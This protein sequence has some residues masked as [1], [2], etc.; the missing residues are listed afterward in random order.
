M[1][2]GSQVPEQSPVQAHEQRFESKSF[3]GT[4]ITDGGNGQPVENVTDSRVENWDVAAV[5]SDTRDPFFVRHADGEEVLD[6]DWFS[7]HEHVYPDNHPFDTEEY[8]P[9]QSDGDWEQL[10]S[11]ADVSE[12]VDEQTREIQSSTGVGVDPSEFGDGSSSS[13]LSETADSEPSTETTSRVGASGLDTDTLRETQLIDENGNIL[14]EGSDVLQSDA[15]A[16]AIATVA[17]NYDSD[18]IAS[19]GSKIQEL[20]QNSTGPV[21]IHDSDVASKFTQTEKE[22]I[23]NWQFTGVE[24]VDQ[25]TD[26]EGRFMGATV[27]EH[28]SETVDD[29]A[30]DFDETGELVVATH[31][32]EYAQQVTESVESIATGRSDVDADELVNKIHDQQV[33]SH[34]E[35]ISRNNQSVHEQVS[36][37]LSDISRT[38]KQSMQKSITETSDAAADLTTSEMEVVVE[39]TTDAMP[40]TNKAAVTGEVASV[41]GYDV[42][43]TLDYGS[44]TSSTSNARQL[45][46][47]IPGENVALVGSSEATKNS[48]TDTLLSINTDADG[49]IYK[50]QNGEKRAQTDVS[51]EELDVVRFDVTETNNGDVTATVTDSGSVTDVSKAHTHKYKADLSSKTSDV[52]DSDEV[53]VKG[54]DEEVDAFNDNSKAETNVS[55]SSPQETNDPPTQESVPTQQELV[56]A[57]ES[58]FRG[59]EGVSHFSLIESESGSVNN[60]KEQGTDAEVRVLNAISDDFD[61]NDVTESDI[62]AAEENQF[63]DC[64]R[65]MTEVKLRHV[66]NLDSVSLGQSRN[67]QSSETLTEEDSLSEPASQSPDSQWAEENTTPENTRYV[68]V[69]YSGP[70]GVDAS[71]IDNEEREE[72]L[73]R[74]PSVRHK[75]WNGDRQAQPARIEGVAVVSGQEVGDTVPE[76]HTFEAKFD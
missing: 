26:S 44:V 65:S 70:E 47:V 9:N 5:A 1:G 46:S 56:D 33:V 28:G 62:D 36:N 71:E 11:D 68:T 51:P 14:E 53:V 32:N 48:D 23:A 34:A 35:T 41:L 69:V 8:G 43:H 39:A 25:Y 66:D 19:I 27:L 31:A 52:R 17:N 60:V 40:I 72:I 55:I 3:Q 57:L 58:E 30:G 64:A 6:K 76:K 59:D 20:R 67:P 10:E 15:T 50:Q 63:P 2:G 18:Y 75:A 12:S 45:Q 24:S 4:I 38:N 7:Q 16:N 49:N 13:S 74:Q 42:N 37:M 73:E 22:I 54:A 21:N 29:I 61:P